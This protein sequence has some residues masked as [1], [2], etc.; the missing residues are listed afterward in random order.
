MILLH[1]HYINEDS[2]TAFPL[3]GF[4]V[5]HVLRDINK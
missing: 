5:T 2:F 1:L 4:L 3:F